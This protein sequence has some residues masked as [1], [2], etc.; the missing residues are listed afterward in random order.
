MAVPLSS[1][2][3]V[4]GRAAVRTAP[5]LAAIFMAAHHNGQP[6]MIAAHPASGSTAVATVLSV[7]DPLSQWAMRTMEGVQEQVREVM[8]NAER[9]SPPVTP[10]RAPAARTLLSPVA[11]IY[12]RLLGDKG[13]SLGPRLPEQLVEAVD[14]D[15]PESEPAS[16]NPDQVRQ[17]DRNDE[18]LALTAAIVAQ[19]FGDQVNR[20][21][22]GGAFDVTVFRNVYSAAQVIAPDKPLSSLKPIELQAI[23][24]SA[25]YSSNSAFLQHLRGGTAIPSM[26]MDAA[27]AVLDGGKAAA[28]FMEKGQFSESAYRKKIQSAAIDAAKI[29]GATPTS[30]KLGLIAVAGEKARYVLS[31]MKRPAA[32]RDLAEEQVRRSVNDRLEAMSMVEQPAERPTAAAPG[33]M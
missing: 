19:G 11:D 12:K 32:W 23:V 29:T 31:A 1:D 9:T 5:R 17:V 13:D 21:Q 6:L 18:L 3:E 10:E 4:L 14:S 28:E 30:V 24:S 2:A 8:E 25:L 22:T 33:V 15:E 26:V 27:K 16:G 20:V 7:A